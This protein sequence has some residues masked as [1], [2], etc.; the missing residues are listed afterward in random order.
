MQ[1]RKN[2]CKLR[3]H[4]SHLAPSGRQPKATKLATLKSNIPQSSA[5]EQHKSADRSNEKSGEQSRG[6]AGEEPTEL[7][8]QRRAKVTKRAAGQMRRV[9]SQQEPANV[10][11]PNCSPAKGVLADALS[12]ID[13]PRTLT[14]EYGIHSQKE[15]PKQVSGQRSHL[16]ASGRQPIKPKM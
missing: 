7:K 15:K 1:P 9:S 10:P 3:G 14:S 6:A 13:Q 4:R 5:D 11:R 8:K 12:R 2:N 16:R